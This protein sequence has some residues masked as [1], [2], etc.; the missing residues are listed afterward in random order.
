M[1]LGT[2]RREI[3]ESSHIVCLLGLSVASDCGC[4]NYR[5]SDNAYAVE[6][7]YGYS[8][9]EIFSAQFFNTRPK[10]FFEYYHENILG[11]L[12]TPGPALATLRRLE[13]ERRVQS[14]ITRSIYG[15]PGRAGIRRYIEMHGSV[16]QNHCPHCGAKFPLE[17]MMQA[18][19]IPLCPHCGNVVRPDIVLDGEMIPNSLVTA[20]AS[21]VE[22]ADTLLIL[23]CSMKATLVRNAISYFDGKRIILINEE[24]NPSDRAADLVFYGKPRDILP[25]IYT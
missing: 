7:K 4:F 24:E 22:R 19:G 6:T 20:S 9:E 10:M 13:D 3:R 1:D 14:V 16:Y 11:K 21:E 2:L 17:F 23:G 5:D 25:G 15:L 12:G 8:P 18:E